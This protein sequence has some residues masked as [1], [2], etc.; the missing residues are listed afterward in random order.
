M[1]VNVGWM[2]F[3]RELDRTSGLAHGRGGC[4]IATFGV[5]RVGIGPWCNLS[6]VGARLRGIVWWD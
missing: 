6:A 4:G 5:S 3:D 2:S 1:S